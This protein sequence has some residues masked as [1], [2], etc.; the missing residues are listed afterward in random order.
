MENKKIL[1]IEHTIAY[2][3][4]D[5]SL[6]IQALTHSSHSANH[7]E[8]LEFLGDSVLSIIVTTFIYNKYH[9]FNEGELS[10][11]R[12]YVVCKDVLASIARQFNLSFYL[13]LGMGEL[14]TGGSKKPS[15]LADALEAVIGA[16]YIDIATTNKANATNDANDTNDKFDKIYSIICP[17]FMQYIEDSVAGKEKDSKS[18]L[19][20]YLQGKKLAKPVY[21]LTKKSGQDHAQIFTMECHLPSANMKF[22]GV[23]QTKKEAEKNAADLALDYLE[24]SK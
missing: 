19:Q 16:I 4:N 3:F 7:N 12:S 9:G 6:L 22:T 11:I 20:E 21:T 5:K 15:I 2:S 23:A 13:Q 17:W 1:A 24:Q 18:R 10:R 8:R 14:K